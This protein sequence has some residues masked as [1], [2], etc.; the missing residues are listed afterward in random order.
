MRRA[1]T[2]RGR[3]SQ[4]GR[5]WKG[6][7]VP[8]IP[9]L[10]EVHTESELRQ[11]VALEVLATPRLRLSEPDP[12]RNVLKRLVEQEPW[13]QEARE[14]AEVE[15]ERLGFFSNP[16]QGPQRY[17]GAVDAPGL[18]EALRNVFR[19]DEA[20]PLSASALSRFGNCGFQGFLTY[21]LRVAEPDEPG[22]AFDNRRRGTFWHKV[23][24]RLF[25]VLRERRLLGCAPEEIPEELVDEVLEEVA[26]SFEESHHVGHHRLWELARERARSMVRR[27]LADEHRGL[28][29][30]AYEPAHFELPFGPKRGESAWQGITL[31]VAGETVHFEGSID[32]LDRPPGKSEDVGV[33][34]YKS[35]RLDKRELKANLL[36][37]DFQLPLYLYAARVAGFPEARNA[38]WFSLR[39]GEII[40]LAQLL[41]PQELEDLLSTDGE[42]R[43]RL[44]EQGGLNLPNAVETVVRTGRAGQFPVRP[45]DCGACGYRAVCRIT[46]RRIV[47]ENAHG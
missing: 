2:S 19:F 9:P 12:A 43:A 36:S 20:R 23:V 6:R 11:R 47:E 22:E 38:A 4:A 5:A 18:D 14:L 27:I 39:T 24:E 8:P 28:P 26:K 16:K 25:Q 29:F 1:G 7:S 42:H 45:K 46:E 21:G 35:G 41:S 44:A 13:F 10:E 40:Q 33:I 32:R 30:E 15:Y 37:S 17:T 34:D 3:T 31:E